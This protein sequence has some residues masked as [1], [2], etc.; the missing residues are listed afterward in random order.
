MIPCQQRGESQKFNWEE[1][2]LKIEKSRI[3]FSYKPQ[4]YCPNLVKSSDIRIDN[5]NRP[6]F[7]F[8]TEMF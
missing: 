4:S 8:V 5:D 7:Y 2:K 6:V 3:F 1:N